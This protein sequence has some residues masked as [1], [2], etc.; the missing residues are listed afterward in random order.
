M[1][2]V[3][4]PVPAPTPP[5]PAPLPSF[6]TPAP[7]SLVPDAVGN[8]VAWASAR[9][10]LAMVAVAWGVLAFVAHARL[11][12]WRQQR[13]Q[14]H[15]QQITITPPLEVESDSAARWWATCAEI[16]RPMG[17]RRLLYGTPHVGFE[18]RWAGRQLTI[19]IWLPGTVPAGPVL[20]AVAGAWPGATA[21]VGDAADPIPATVIA[22]GDA[23]APTLPAWYPI[24]TGHDSDPLRPLISALSGLGEHEYACVQVLARPATRRQV[25]RLRAG[26]AALRTGQP[27]RGAFDPATWLEGIAGLLMPGPGR[28]S[29]GAGG[30]SVAYR[31]PVGDPERER[32]ARAAVDKLASGQLWESSIRYGIAHTNPRKAGEDTLRA[33]LRT[34]AHGAAS[35]YGLYTAR[36]RLR[37]VR[38]ARAAAVLAGRPLR[39]GYLLS[40]AELAA[41]AALPT[42][43]AVPGLVRARA[44]PMPAPVEAPSGGRGVK[45]LGRA[46]IGGHTVALPVVDARQHLHV[47]GSTGVG[48]STFLVNLILDDV[49]ARRG[50]VVIDPKGDLVT[51]VLDRLDPKVADRVV[52]IDPDQAQGGYFNP[53]SGDDHDLAVDNV[54]SI[55]SKIFQRHWGPRIDDT[56][57]V[58]CLTLMRKANA[59]LALVPPL[60]ND[61]QFRTAF[62]QDLDDPEGLLGY[63]TWYESMPPPVRAQVIGPVMA[64]LR[65]FLLRDFPRRTLGTPRSSFDM[66]TLLNTGGILLARLPKGQLGEDTSRLMGSFVLARAWQAA[67]ARAKL[68]EDKRRDCTVYIDECHNFLNLPGSVD[69]M[70]AEARGYRMSLV[71]AHQDLAQ[72][73]RPTQLALSA[74]ARNKITF[75][76][77]PEDAHQMARHMFPE[78]SEH[79]LSHLDAYQAA[80]RLVINNRETAAFTLRARPPRPSIPGAADQIRRACAAASRSAGDPTAIEQLAKRLATQ[81]EGRR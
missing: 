1:I 50:V 67:T 21:T 9:P 81:P 60:L 23:L 43:L 61:K 56:L 20:A 5:T 64:R 7:S 54:V 44:R 6:G 73:P 10:W 41:V 42:D 2:R 13:W 65:A 58:A 25:R 75:N 39:S 71:L 24:V 15:A 76:V 4:S 57:R 30:R 72:L 53:L 79:D 28:A 16:L 77:A 22:E 74:N 47:L 38:L 46:Q 52:L 19:V 27:A 12:R 34:L 55:F 31:P 33:R 11:L 63:W 35:A 36:Q 69:D 45:Q 78:L 26:T 59:T 40:V 70:L 68:P 66:E 18:Y 48:K 62:T 8:A 14:R 32:D 17:W 3:A 51:D 37:R 49:A 29:T 80:A